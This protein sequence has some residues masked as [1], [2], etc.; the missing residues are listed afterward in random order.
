WLNPD[1]GSSILGLWEGF[2]T[3]DDIEV[4]DDHT[5]VLNLG[6]PLLAVP[7]QLF[8][9]PAQIMH[10]SFDGDITSGKNPS[11]GPYTLDEYV[12]GERVRV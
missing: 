10:P 9:Y 7:E 8:H 11:T 12:E 6:G 3:V 2:L 4:R 1:T 5:V